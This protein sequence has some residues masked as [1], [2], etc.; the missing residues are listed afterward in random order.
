LRRYYDLA[1]TAIPR[2]AVIAVPEVDREVGAQPDRIT[3]QR[4]LF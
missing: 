4:S 1:K 2:L 3:G